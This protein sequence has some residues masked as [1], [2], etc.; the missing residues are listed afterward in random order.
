MASPLGITP[1]GILALPVLALALLPPPVSVL[2]IFALAVLSLSVSLLLVLDQPGN[3]SFFYAAV[4]KDSS[5]AV[6]RRISCF[7]D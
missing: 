4:E 3:D 2:P 7:A 6:L 1:A 5:I